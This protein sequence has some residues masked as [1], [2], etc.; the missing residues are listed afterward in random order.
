MEYVNLNGEIFKIRYDSVVDKLEADVKCNFKIISLIKKHKVVSALIGLTIAA[1]G[2][3]LFLIY[4]F[5]KVLA[6][7]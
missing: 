3:N 1:V 2:I 7:G 5:F 4:M 6:G